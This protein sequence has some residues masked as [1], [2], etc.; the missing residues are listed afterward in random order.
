MDAY[1][2]HCVLAI[3]NNNDESNP[4][5][6]IICNNINTTVDCKTIFYINPKFYRFLIFV[7]FLAKNINFEPIWIAMNGTHVIISSYTS[8]MT[9]QY[10][11]PKSYSTSITN[12]KL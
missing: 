3:R 4:Y 8:F 6:L 7:I 9:W 5:S 10:N 2:D 1:K 12:G 11:V